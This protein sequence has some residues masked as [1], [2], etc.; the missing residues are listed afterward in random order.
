MTGPRD[1]LPDGSVPALDEQPIPAGQ[2]AV[3][4]GAAFIDLLTAV[5][6]A[7]A[8]AMAAARALD[9]SAATPKSPLGG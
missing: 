3:T 5:M 7:E 6:K 2:A 9:Q 4:V 8:I 1:T